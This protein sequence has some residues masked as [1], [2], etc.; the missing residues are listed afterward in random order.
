MDNKRAIIISINF[1]TSALARLTVTNNKICRP[2]SSSVSRE[3]YVT[4]EVRLRPRNEH[5]PESVGPS[6]LPILMPHRQVKSS[7][8]FVITR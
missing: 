8:R 1:Q 5:W 2:K 7:G 6:I 3:N 4:R